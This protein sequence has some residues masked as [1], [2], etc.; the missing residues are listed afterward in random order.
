MPWARTKPDVRDRLVL[1]GAD[2]IGRQGLRASTVR[3]LTRHCQTPEG[4][5]YHYFPGGKQE[6]AAEAV[7]MN[8]TLVSQV[9]S[10]VSGTARW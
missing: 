4:S 1:G 8:G 6:L 3:D 5:T 10:R 2:P 7:R 9:V